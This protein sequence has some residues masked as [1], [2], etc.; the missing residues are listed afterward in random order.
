MRYPLLF[1]MVISSSLLAVCP[2]PMQAQVEPSNE[3]SP[4]GLSN[5]QEPLPPLA[6]PTLTFV[7]RET[8]EDL[9]GLVIEPRVASYISERLNEVFRRNGNAYILGCTEDNPCFGWMTKWGEYL[10]PNL[11]F[12]VAYSLLE[13]PHLNAKGTGLRDVGEPFGAWYIGIITGKPGPDRFSG[14][15]VTKP[16]RNEITTGGL[17][18]QWENRLVVFKNNF[19]VPKVTFAPMH[20]PQTKPP[21]PGLRQP[22][23]L[24]KAFNG[25]LNRDSDDPV[26][27]KGQY[28]KE[29]GPDDLN[30]YWVYFKLISGDKRCQAKTPCFGCIVIHSGTKHVL[31][32]RKGTVGSARF[33]RIGVYPEQNNFPAGLTVEFMEKQLE[34]LISKLPALVIKDTTYSARHLG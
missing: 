9:E 33:E 31:I 19:M 22:A 28:I 5:Q 12:L 17:Q 34:N 15:P 20:V 24:T 7:D 32:V 1:T 16:G 13:R 4:A 29:P 30:S 23:D 2:L 26:I 25:A 6:F 18:K 14:K 27:Y 8:G 3:V 11:V 10:L 21:P